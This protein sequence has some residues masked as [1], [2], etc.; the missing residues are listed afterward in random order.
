LFVFRL[1]KQ[2]TSIYI[3][4][5]YLISKAIEKEGRA[6]TPTCHTGLIPDE[7]SR[8]TTK[9]SGVL[10]IGGNVSFIRNSQQLGSD[11]IFFSAFPLYD[12]IGK[13]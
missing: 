10:D 9:V 2:Q 8:Y 3:R 5:L 11:K 7:I 6:D 13:A 1:W 12:P 4:T